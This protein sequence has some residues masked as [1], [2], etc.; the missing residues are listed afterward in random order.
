MIYLI[1]YIYIYIY[2]MNLK[3]KSSHLLRCR[4]PRGNKNRKHWEC[5]TLRRILETS[6][7]LWTPLLWSSVLTVAMYPWPQQNR[8]IY[9]WFL[10]FPIWS[11]YQ[12]IECT[13]VQLKKSRLS[14][15][16]NLPIMIYLNFNELA[17]VIEICRQRFTKIWHTHKWQPVTPVHTYRMKHFV[18]AY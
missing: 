3:I 12:Q 5:Q 6:P 18:S 1:Y 4:S 14:R 7:C 10:L 2:T 8:V 15:A 17:R 11:P 13:W 9:C 16:P